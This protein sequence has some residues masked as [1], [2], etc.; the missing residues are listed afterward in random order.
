MARDDAYLLLKEKL[1]G[2]NTEWSDEKS[3]RQ[4]WLEDGLETLVEKLDHIPLALV[5]AASYLRETSLSTKDYLKSLEANELEL[6]SLLEHDSRKSNS[7]TDHI[8]AAIMSIWSLAIEKM[9][10]QCGPAVDLL[11]LMAFF[12]N[13]DIP[14]VLL[15]G[16]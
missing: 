8:V 3:A 11:S 14:V 15:R 5:Q 9:E 16:F 12:N 6:T 7:N 10:I 1:A 2:R 13:Q 4:N